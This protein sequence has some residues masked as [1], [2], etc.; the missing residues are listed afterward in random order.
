MD[1]A[2][3]GGGSRRAAIAT[4]FREQHAEAGLEIRFQVCH[5]VVNQLGIAMAEDDQWTRVLGA[6]PDTR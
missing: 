5:P 4:E 1:D 2:F 3:L 6:G